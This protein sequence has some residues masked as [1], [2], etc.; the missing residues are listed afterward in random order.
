MIF[1]VQTLNILADILITL[2]FARVIF[3]WFQ[4]HGWLANFL[5]SA[6]E[7][8]LGPIKKLMPRTGMI[9]F[10]PIIAYILIE[11]IRTIV[12]NYLV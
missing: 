3:S 4:M 2:I 10:S 5:V 7:P 11:V 12:N 9:D 8:I 1:I 6:T